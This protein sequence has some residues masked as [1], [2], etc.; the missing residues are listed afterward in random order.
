M[1]L[2]LKDKHVLIAGGSKGIGLACAKSFLAEGSK[3]TIISRAQ[4]NFDNITCLTAD[5]KSL[6]QAKLAVK[7][8]IA[9][10]GDIDILVN[11]AGSARKINPLDVTPEDYMIAFQS[12]FFTY[13]NTMH[14]VLE[15]MS[16]GTIVNVVG[17][18]GKLAVPTH[19]P[20]GSA[21]A[22]LL[23]ASIGMAGI[24]VK[25]GIRINCVNPVATNTDILNQAISVDMQINGLTKDE[26]LEKIKNRFPTNR[27]L[28]PNEVA[29]AVLFLS[30]KRSDYI[31]GSCI[32]LDG[33]S[34]SIL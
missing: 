7:E 19:L 14:A 23:L 9:I 26:A 16:K 1:D 13:I 3:V 28:E 12:K 20:G 17:L 30:S 22:A 24:Y 8:A 25:K 33:G 27:I 2:Y 6:D 11:C 10:N 5:L 32:Y 31:N 21:N 15:K 29:D 34:L 4:V 18:G